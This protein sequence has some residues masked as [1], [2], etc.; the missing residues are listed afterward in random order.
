MRYIIHGDVQD[1][2]VPQGG[3][4]RQVNDTGAS[5]ILFMYSDPIIKDYCNVVSCL[6]VALKLN[7]SL[8]S[9]SFRCVM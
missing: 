3:T 6:V 1:I 7:V 2:Q 8:S 9:Y 5:D 4:S